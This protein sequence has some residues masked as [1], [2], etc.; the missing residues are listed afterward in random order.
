MR[1]KNEKPLNYDRWAKKTKTKRRVSRNSP[2]SI[3]REVEE[4]WKYFWSRRKI[5]I[6]RCTHFLHQ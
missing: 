6:I 5:G 3:K 4:G 2:A 1:A